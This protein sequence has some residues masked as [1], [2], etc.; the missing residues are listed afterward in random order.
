MQVIDSKQ[1]VALLLLDLSAVFDTVDHKILLNCLSTRIEIRAQLFSIYL[2]PLAVV[3]QSHGLD[4]NSMLMMVH[5]TLPSNQGI[6]RA[7]KILD[8]AL[9][10]YC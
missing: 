5:Y 3:I 1:A 6:M 4:L 9:S 7:R 10:I 8:L 2:L